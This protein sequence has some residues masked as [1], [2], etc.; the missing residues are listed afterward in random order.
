LHAVQGASAEYACRCCQT[1]FLNPHTLNEETL[2]RLCR[3]GRSPVDAAH[4]FGWYEGTLRRLIHLYKYETIVSL[5]Q[6]L[7]EMAV[8]ALPSH[9]QYDAVVPVPMHWRKRADRGF[10]QAWEL[11]RE[12]SRRTGVPMARGLERRR[13][14]RSQTGLSGPE[15]RK[16]LAGVY[17]ARPQ[18]GL[19]G[20]SVLLVDDVWTT[21]STVMM[22]AAALK[23][24]GVSR[25]YGLTVARVD[26]R[27]LSLAS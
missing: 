16:S 23:Q 14:G 9:G 15:R 12:V 22:C 1:P 10:D 26:R 2:C 11:A 6:P 20:K 8:R 5:A 18:A 4:S 24:A 17:A 27:P 7:G 13:H 25:V 21:G 3:S 19:T